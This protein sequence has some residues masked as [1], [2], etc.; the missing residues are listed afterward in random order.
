[1][2]VTT[3]RDAICPPPAALALADLVASSEKRHVTIPGGHVGAVVGEK[4]RTQLF[5]ALAEFFRE[6]TKREVL[7]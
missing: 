7:S 3:S 1:M 4:A 2:T 6:T 5:P